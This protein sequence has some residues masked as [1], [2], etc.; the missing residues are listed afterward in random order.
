MKTKKI[1]LK[2]PRPHRAQ[3]QVL[4]EAKRFNVLAC[5]RRWGK[6]TIGLDIIIR[7]AIAGQPVAWFAPYYK[8]LLDVWRQATI[9][10]APMIQ[11]KNA[12]E[13]RIELIGGG[14]I[15]FWSLEDIDVARGRKY[16]AVVI[17]EAAMVRHL[18][19]AWRCDG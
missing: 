5:G 14:L 2:L 12:S 10:L 15:E 3:R 9:T 11:K 19:D 17:D 1:D 13:R 16:K 4:R 8:S 18:K 6:T 7:H